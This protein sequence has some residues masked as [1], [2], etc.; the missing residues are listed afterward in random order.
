MPSHKTPVWP[1]DTLLVCMRNARRDDNWG[2]TRGARA[3]RAQ[4]EEK[5][6][7]PTDYPRPT[8]QSGE[9]LYPFT[10]GIDLTNDGLG[11]GE[12]TRLPLRL[13]DGTEATRIAR[14]TRTGSRRFGPGFPG[15]GLGSEPQV[16]FSSVNESLGRS[17]VTWRVDLPGQPEDARRAGRRDK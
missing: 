14:R 11:Y 7:P 4:G 13:P 15:S 12:E 2:G 5:P 16:A 3:E 8:L 9:A 1:V 17:E 6:R 10:K